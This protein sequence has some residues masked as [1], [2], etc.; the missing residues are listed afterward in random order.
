M[1]HVTI[2]GEKSENGGREVDF[3][4]SCHVCNKELFRISENKRIIHNI[5]KH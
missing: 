2:E 5:S 4:I 3:V 1:W